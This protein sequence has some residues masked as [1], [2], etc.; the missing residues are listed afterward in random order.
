MPCGTHDDAPVIHMMLN[1]VRRVFTT[2][3]Y[4]EVAGD[5]GALDAIAEA[6]AWYQEVSI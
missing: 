6:A 1:P 2:G 5:E 3:C 4:D